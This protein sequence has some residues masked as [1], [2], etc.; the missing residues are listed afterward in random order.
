MVVIKYRGE[1]DQVLVISFVFEY[2]EFVLILTRDFD[3]LNGLF[4][5]G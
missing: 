1:V 3:R 4:D 2:L 5:V